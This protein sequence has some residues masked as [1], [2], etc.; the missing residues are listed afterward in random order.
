MTSAIIKFIERNE[1]YELKNVDF[2]VRSHVDGYLP[3]LS[4]EGNVIRALSDCA[5][6][7]Y[8]ETTKPITLSEAKQLLNSIYGVSSVNSMGI[9]DVIF[10]D[11][12]TIVLWKDGTKTVV[13]C[14]ENDT[15]SKETGLAMAICKKFFGNKSNYNDVFKQ[16]IK[17]D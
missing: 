7:E 11:P 12:A 4:L 10:N 15:F 16:W 2:R 5:V 8:L 9:K 6:S 3:I 14:Q 13:K 1:M 17:E